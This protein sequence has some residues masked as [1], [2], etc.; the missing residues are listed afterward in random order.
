VNHAS[1][2]IESYPEDI[3]NKNDTNALQSLANDQVA[4]NKAN[5][6]LETEFLRIKEL[7]NDVPLDIRQKLTK[8]QNVIKNAQQLTKLMVTCCRGLSVATKRKGQIKVQPTSIA[9]R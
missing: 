3:S 4:S 1:Y 9:R 6:G 2:H 7:L 5:D 8:N